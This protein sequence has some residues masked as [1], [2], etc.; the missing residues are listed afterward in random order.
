MKTKYVI[1][2]STL[3]DIADSIRVMEE[4]DGEVPVN[5]YAERIRKI[6]P[7]IEDFMRIS[8]YIGEPKIINEEDYSIAEQE[9][10]KELLDFYAIEEV[11]SNG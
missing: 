9:Q 8:D 5:E 11:D 7:T 2:E 3:K 4:T 10:C 6:E 1:D